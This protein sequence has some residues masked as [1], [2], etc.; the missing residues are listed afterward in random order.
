MCLGGFLETCI[1]GLTSVSMAAYDL[2]SGMQL[3]L[4]ACNHNADLCSLLIQERP[5]TRCIKRHI[6]HL[7]HDEPREPPRRTRGEQGHTAGEDEMV[8]KQD[9]SPTARMVQTLDQQQVDQQ[10]LQEAGL[11]IGSSRSTAQRPPVSSTAL[12]NL[13]TGQ[14]S[15]E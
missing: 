12:N 13:P 5:C 15:C 1:R 14:A 8:S 6:G 3:P 9:E 2:R 11:S 10:F 4:C 7:C